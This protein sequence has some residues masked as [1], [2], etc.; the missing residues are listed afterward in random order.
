MSTRNINVNR[1][2]DEYVV[3]GKALPYLAMLIG[4]GLVFIAAV[5]T[6]LGVW[7]QYSFNNV[8]AQESNNALT[9][10]LC[11][12]CVILTALAWKLFRSRDQIHHY[13]SWHA[14]ITSVLVHAWLI[15]AVWQDSGEWM[16]GVP[17]VYTYFYGGAIIGLSWCIRRWAYRGEEQASSESNVFEAIGLGDGTHIDGRNSRKIDS[18]AKYRLKL[19]LGKTIDMAKEKR[20]QLAHIAGKP[21]SQVLVSETYDRKAGEV[22][23]TILDD[24]PFGNK[25][26]WAGPDYPGQSI[27]APITFATYDTGERPE[28]YLAGMNG[29]SSQHFLV[30]GMSGSGKSKAWQAIYGSVLNRR[31]VSVLFG[32][33]AKGMQTG[34]PL[35]S[36][37]EWFATT[38]PDCEKMIDAVIE[39]IPARTNYL[40][41][42]GLDHWMP[43]C[44]LNFLI[45]HLEE[46]ARFAKVDKLIELI[47]AARS[48]GIAIVISLQRAT[49]DRL[50][51]SA[52]Y[53]LGANMCFGVKMKSDARFGL[54][55]YAVTS[56]AEPHKWQD[57]YPGQ[58]YLEAQGVD[59]RMAGH[60]LKTD[61]INIAKLQLAVDAGQEAR[62]VLDEPT[63]TALGADYVAYRN[64]VAAGN[65][66]W[67]MLRRS[68][69]ARVDTK[70]LGLGQPQQLSLED[71]ETIDLTL[72]E[73]AESVAVKQEAGI[74][75]NL[76]TDPAE[77]ALARQILWDI[78]QDFHEHGKEAFFPRDV[79]ALYDGPVRSN[80]WFSDQL[81][82]WVKEGRLRKRTI[83]DYQ[84]IT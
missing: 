11:V 67:Q 3:F 75:S 8:P 74:R 83:G 50:K 37:L 18:G 17:V 58:F 49:N 78:I 70:D 10:I 79:I 6:R 35:A 14:A 63:A 31:D 51:T 40:T 20:E 45:F 77:T 84:I 57:R 68:K 30:M 53:N 25:V 38:Q 26:E 65:T 76:N 44:G 42:Q 29:S 33:P 7:A 52:R 22:D 19:A 16:F 1:Y 13:I 46:A 27:V 59:V 55:E 54:S 82:R 62:S 36:G 15:M 60:A 24:N 71:L 23:V 80:K 2:E 73:T 39:A 48:A 81:S 56:G 34:G 28:L 64:Q 43:D 4:A 41:S 66:D 9:I 5:I 61:W 12:S 32:D 72:P 21:V 47:E 69:G